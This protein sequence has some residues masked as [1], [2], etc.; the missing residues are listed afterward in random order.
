[1]FL[2]GAGIVLVGLFG[3]RSLR[4]YHNIAHLRSRGALREPVRTDAIQPWMTVRYVAVAY[5]VPEEYIFAQ[6]NI[7]FDQRNSNDTLKQLNR[8]FEMGIMPDGKVPVIIS[9]VADAVQSYHENPVATGLDDIRPWMTIRYISN[10]TGVPEW[11]LLQEVE[12]DTD[13]KYVLRQLDRLADDLQYPEG[14]RGLLTAIE[15]ALEQYEGEGTE[16]V[17]ANLPWEES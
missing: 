9:L 11:Y 1:M 16:N 13:E 6:L 2:I 7:R 3:V 10:S 12:I 8:R 17:P 15:A 14:I 4:A 5:S